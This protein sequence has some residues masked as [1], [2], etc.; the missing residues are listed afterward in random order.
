MNK[1]PDRL[2][3]F[4]FAPSPQISQQTMKRTSTAHWEGTGKEGKGTLTT[5]T[6]VLS[7]QPYNWSSRFADGTQT[8]PEE[9]IAA[10]HAGCFSMKLS[11]VLNAAGYTP[12][13]IDTKCTIT[14]ED[15]TITHSDLEVTA[16][17]P[18][19][20][21]QGFADCAEEAKRNCPVSK[22]LKAQISLKAALAD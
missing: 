8:N 19:I 22:L 17:V 12:A 14:I 16:S 5:A 3:F 6:G 1:P 10:A 21:P 20:H 18:G 13:S 11:F 9:L 15:G 4:I 7:N 2:F